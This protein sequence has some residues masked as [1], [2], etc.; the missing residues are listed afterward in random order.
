MS[1]QQQQPTNRSPVSPWQHAR[2]A[3][4]LGWQ[5][6]GLWL[7]ALASVSL[8]IGGIGP[9]ATS[10]GVITVSGTSM[11]GWRE[12]GVG[13]FCLVML[14]LH[15]LRGARLPLVM[16]GVAAALGAMLAIAALS[17]I[18]SGGAVTVLGVQ[19]RYMDAAWGLYLVLAGT[20]TLLVCALALAWRGASGAAETGG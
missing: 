19:Y 14:G 7:A 16:A 20:I 13:V 6:V 3:P 18:S 2:V 1:E 17:K 4:M 5:P 15:L 11:H 12:V 8:I 10:F 9:W